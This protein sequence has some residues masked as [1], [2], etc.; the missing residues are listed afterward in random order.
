[1]GVIRCQGDCYVQGTSRL[2]A[3]SDYA[4]G[5][6]GLLAMNDF[7]FGI[8]LVIIFTVVA[9]GWYLAIEWVLS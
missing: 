2:L 5:K 1:M 7:L 3:V 6:H 4:E 9:V 8:R